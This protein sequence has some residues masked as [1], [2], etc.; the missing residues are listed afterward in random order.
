MNA[1]RLLTHFVM[2]LFIDF[3]IFLVIY[4]SIVCLFFYMP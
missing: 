2:Y 4:L 3:G 1:L